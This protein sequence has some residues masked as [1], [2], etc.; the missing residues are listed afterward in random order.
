MT[1]IR[2]GQ[3]KPACRMEMDRIQAPCLSGM[4]RQD[5]KKRGGESLLP[6]AAKNVT[7]YLMWQVV[8]RALAALFMRRNG[9]FVLSCTLW[10]VAHC[11]VEA[12]KSGRPAATTVATG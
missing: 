3:A 6:P 10:Q 12:V 7:V 11:I 5:R 9:T 2:R 8:Q 4:P 1:L